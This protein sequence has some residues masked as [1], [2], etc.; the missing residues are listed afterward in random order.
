VFEGII[1]RQ[2]N[3]EQLAGA[4][5]SACQLFNAR[6]LRSFLKKK[7]R[8]ARGKSINGALPNAGTLRVLKKNKG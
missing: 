7:Q 6:S 5:Q 8:A 1:F 3:N 4:K 2:P